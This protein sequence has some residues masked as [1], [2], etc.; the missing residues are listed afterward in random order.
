MI[1]Q[2]WPPDSKR[3]LLVRGKQNGPKLAWSSWWIP[4]EGGEINCRESLVARRWPNGVTCPQCGSKDEAK[5]LAYSA[6]AE[7][8]DSGVPRCPP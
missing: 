1:V 8:I 2:I 4:A 5:R 6:A 7:N 3:I